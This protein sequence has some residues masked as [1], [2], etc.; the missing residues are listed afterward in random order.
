MITTLF[1]GESIPDTQVH[2]KIEGSA[3]LQA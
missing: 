1:N 3:L 2:S